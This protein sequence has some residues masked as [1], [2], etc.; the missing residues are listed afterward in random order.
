MA[1]DVDAK[2]V[3][4]LGFVEFAVNSSANTSTGKALFELVYGHNICEV[5]DYLDGMHTVATA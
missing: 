3:D 5:V 4:R 2:W 1:V